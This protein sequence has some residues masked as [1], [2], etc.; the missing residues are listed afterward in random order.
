[1]R[2]GEISITSSTNPN[3]VLQY[4]DVVQYDLNTLHVTMRSFKH[5]GQVTIT[6]QIMAEHND[7][8]PIKALSA[9]CLL[10]GSSPG[11]LFIFPSG[12]PITRS[13]FT[14]QLRA[15]LQWANLDT[16]RYKGHSFRIGPATTAAAN[17]FSD[18]HI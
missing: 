9:Y 8:C 1:M 18:A 5:S 14:L 12:N 16:H 2:I 17:G 15:A 4:E 13:F 11:P 6:L 10:R 3:H 7:I